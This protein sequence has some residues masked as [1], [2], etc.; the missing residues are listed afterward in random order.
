VADEITFNYHLTGP[1]TA[2]VV[3]FLHGF[4]GSGD[5]WNEVTEGLGDRFRCLTVDLPGHGG[6]RINGPDELYRM[7]STARALID[8]L[9]SHT[10]DTCHLIGYSMGGRLGMYLGLHYPERF[11]RI[12][13]ES[14]SP[15]LTTEAERAA[16]RDHDET[17]AR[18]LEQTPLDQFLGDWYDQPLFASLRRHTQR[19]NRMITARRNNDPAGCIRS[20]LQ[21]GT[22]SMPSL[23][24]MLDA[25][26]E[27]I[28][29]RLLLITGEEDRKFTQIAAGIAALAP[30]TRIATLAGCGHI[31]HLENPEK[32]IR[33]VGE[34]LTE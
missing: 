33:L 25:A 10:I 29:Q 5:D 1:D 30:G 11:D 19:L 32:F 22:G 6:T 21:M 15:G 34:F 16:R 13:L 7:E 18:K 20:L 17:L 24:P 8:L 3:L 14:A 9:D 4:M 27:T 26:G 12:I 2:P 31:V 28:G 23:W